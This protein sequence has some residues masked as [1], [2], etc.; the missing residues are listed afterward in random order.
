MIASGSSGYIV[1][2][3]CHESN[4]SDL[5]LCIFHFNYCYNF[6]IFLQEGFFFLLALKVNI[7]KYT[8]YFHRLIGKN[9]LL[10]SLSVLG[11]IYQNCME[12]ICMRNKYLK[13]A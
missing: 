4:R 3:I 8:A 1:Y 11:K 5:L 13:K 6:Q 9:S 7:M 10:A 12:S 2:L